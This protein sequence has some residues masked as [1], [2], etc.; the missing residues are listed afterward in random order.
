MVFVSWDIVDGFV[1]CIMGYCG[2]FC[3]AFQLCNQVTTFTLPETN[4]APENGPKRPKRKRKS[5]S[6]HP[7]LGAKWLV[8]GRVLAHSH[9]GLVLLPR[10]LVS[11]ILSSKPPACRRAVDAW[12]WRGERRDDRLTWIILEPLAAN[13]SYKCYRWG[14]LG[15]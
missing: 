9:G 15:L 12:R 3:I 8:S 10:S 1:L 2:W 4:M 14:I 11:P 13:L 7:F 6:N 5:S